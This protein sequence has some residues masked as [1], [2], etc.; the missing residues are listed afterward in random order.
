MLTITY[1]DGSTRIVKV[2]V[3]FFFPTEMGGRNGKKTLLSVE[4][5]TKGMVHDFGG[6]PIK[7]ELLRGN[8]V[9]CTLNYFT[10]GIVSEPATKVMTEFSKFP[11]DKAGLKAVKKDLRNAF[12][13]QEFQVT[14]KNIGEITK[15]N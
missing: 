4:E 8:T 15:V 9:F 6:E 12:K 13:R 14:I 2:G 3:D 11:L 1:R 10:P 7:A 5:K